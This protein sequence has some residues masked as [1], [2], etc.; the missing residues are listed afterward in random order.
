LICTLQAC[1]HAATAATCKH[2]LINWQRLKFFLMATV[3]DWS[4]ELSCWG[5]LWCR[6]Q[7]HKITWEL[8]TLQVSFIT[9]YLSISIIFPWIARIFHVNNIYDFPL[10]IIYNFS[11]DRNKRSYITRLRREGLK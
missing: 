10:C 9:F 5:V 8:R 3:L 2:L 6:G 7:T 1:N 4:L 11:K